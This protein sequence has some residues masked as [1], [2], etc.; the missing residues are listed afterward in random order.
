M[1]TSPLAVI[2]ILLLTAV[3]TSAI[4][5][6]VGYWIYD[7]HLKARVQQAVDE[8]IEKLGAT[9]EERVRNGIVQGVASIPS[10]EVIRGTTRT[11][12]ETGVNI[13]GESLGA[14]FGK[15]RKPDE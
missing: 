13:I 9:M 10:V 1:P 8:K 4:T 14:I 15:P 11:M 12:A 2:L 6:G 3:L 7:R 5:L